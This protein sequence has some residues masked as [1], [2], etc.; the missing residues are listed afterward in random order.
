MP[1]WLAPGFRLL[2]R[3]KWLRG[4]PADVFGYAPVR[5]LERALIP[6]YR[7][8]LDVLIQHLT[9][10][11]LGEVTRLAGLPETVRGFEELKLARAN[12]YR[13]DLAEG[14]AKLRDATSA[15]TQTA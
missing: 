4:T 15:R 10:A 14:L 13:A 9:P 1:T 12:R 5:K 8:A 7:A 3:L 6:E 11:N 2:A